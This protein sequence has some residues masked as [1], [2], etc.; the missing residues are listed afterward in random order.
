MISFLKGKLADKESSFACIDCN[1][2]GYEVEIPLSTF[3][4]LPELDQN[5]HVHVH[6]HMTD[7]GI[8]LFGFHTRAEKNMFRKVISISGIGPKL[9]LSILSTLNVSSI[10]NAILLND[11]K[12]LST[13]SGLGKKKAQRLIIELKDKVGDVISHEIQGDEV[14]E[15]DTNYSEALTAL[16][17][18][19]YKQHEIA[20][21]LRTVKESGELLSVEEIVKRTIKHLYKKQ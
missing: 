10:V 2:V 11:T 5:V 9:A 21:V 6:F 7:D 16:V 13:V 17:T 20:K 15:F 12:I 18:L 4:K 14:T 1:G 3:E 19:G 8:R